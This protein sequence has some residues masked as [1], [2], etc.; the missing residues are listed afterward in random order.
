MHKDHKVYTQQTNINSYL[1]L[2]RSLPEKHN[3]EQMVE[4]C[5][6]ILW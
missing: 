4:L 3:L 2:Q 6:R 5:L 1:S